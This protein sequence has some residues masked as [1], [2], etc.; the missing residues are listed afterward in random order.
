MPL[1]LPKM[2]IW[3]LAIRGA[4]FRELWE[5]AGRGLRVARRLIIHS[6]M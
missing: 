6:S 1:S 2:Q 4:T 3:K 5:L